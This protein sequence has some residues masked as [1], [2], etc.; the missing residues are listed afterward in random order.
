MPNLDWLKHPF[1]IDVSTEI[2]FPKAN[3]PTPR[4]WKG[5]AM[6]SEASA[7]T[8][9]QRRRSESNR[10]WRI[11]NQAPLPEIPEENTS[12]AQRAAR[13]IAVDAEILPDPPAVS[14]PTDQDLAL[15]IARCP[16]AHKCSNCEP[17]QTALIHDV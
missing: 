6:L 8:S 15:L 1:G 13:D 5:R 3:R 14:D 17:S 12:F 16:R 2:V 11:C 9:D 10:R 4:Q 7:I